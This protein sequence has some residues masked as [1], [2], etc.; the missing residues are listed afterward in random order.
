MLEPRMVATSIQ[1]RASA[2]HGTSAPADRMTPS[3]HGVLMKAMDAK[4]DAWGS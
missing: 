2:A 3:S 1:V 4:F